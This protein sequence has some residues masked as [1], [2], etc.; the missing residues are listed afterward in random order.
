[1]R[2]TLLVVVLVAG[3]A[4]GPAPPGAP[5][6]TGPERGETAPAEAYLIALDL[7]LASMRA[8]GD[9]PEVFV[10]QDIPVTP[11]MLAARRVRAAP[12]AAP[13]PLE[14][15]SLIEL[16]PA[17]RKTDSTW[18][19]NT[20]EWYRG[21]GMSGGWYAEVQC[22]GEE[23]WRLYDLP[24]NRDEIYGCPAADIQAPR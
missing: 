13:C 2:R 20:R 1:M 15:P 4:G 23:C 18:A 9:E 10:G 11:A 16:L 14:S 7:S 19:V 22:A 21:H 12:D 6:P 3:C 5:H 17:E 8:R 24:V